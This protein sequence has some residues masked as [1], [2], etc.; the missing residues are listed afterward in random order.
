MAV[1]ET[2]TVDRGAIVR[3]W[4]WLQEANPGKF[5]F[6]RVGDF[7]EAYFT[8][9]KLIAKML[10]LS[11][12]LIELPD[13]VPGQVP[14][15]GIP[16]HAKERFK[17]AFWHHGDSALFVEQS[18]LTFAEYQ[19]QSARTAV[20]DGDRDTLDLKLSNFALGIAGEA[21]EVADSIKKHLFH[22]KPL[23]KPALAKEIGDVLWYA[24]QLAE[25]LGLDM[26]DIA[27]G[28]IDKLKARYPD[29]F[30][31][32]DANARKDEAGE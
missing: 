5:V 2:A 17:E 29:G 4:D 30:N 18:N 6:V 27:Q 13:V 3:R 26:G 28:N 22:G 31:S 8:K 9:A 32:A 1:M 23:D 16:Y 21:G 14:M 20:H 11:V 24:S 7:Y 25:S 19:R 10:D 12:S 15:V